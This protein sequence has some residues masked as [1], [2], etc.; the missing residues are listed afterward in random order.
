MI[1]LTWCSSR[2]EAEVVSSVLKANGIAA[3]VSVDSDTGFPT[4]S[5]RVL[6]RDEDLERARGVLTEARAGG[7]Q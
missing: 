2:P 1:C 4:Y 6:V 5:V 3:H 7:G